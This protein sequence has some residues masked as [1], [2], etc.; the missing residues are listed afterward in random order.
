MSAGADAAVVVRAGNLQ[1]GEEYPGHF[2]IIVPAGM[3]EDFR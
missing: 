1:P 2:R 3:D